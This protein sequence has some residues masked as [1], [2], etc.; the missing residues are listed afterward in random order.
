VKYMRWE[1]R[2]EPGRSR[3]EE[4][5]TCLSEGVSLLTSAPASEQGFMV[6]TRAREQKGP[7]DEPGGGRARHSARRARA[8][9]RQV[10]AV[11]YSQRSG[12]QSRRPRS[13]A[14]YSRLG[15]LL[16]GF[17]CLICGLS[18]TRALADTNFDQTSVLIVVGA[19]GEP[20]YETNFVRQA[21]LWEKACDLAGCRQTTL[22]LEP[23]RGT[24]DLD[25]LKEALAAEPRNGNGQFWLVLIGH[26]TFDGEEA[27]F[28]LRGP[29]V[30]DATLAEWL[31]PFRRP[32][33]VIDTTSSSAPFLVKLSATNRVVV[34]ATRSGYEQNF[35]R[36]GLCFAEALSDPE[37]DLDQDGVVS[38]LEAFLSASRKADEFY[39]VQGRIVT[40]HALLDDNGDHLG[41][42][43]D[44]FQGLQPKHKPEGTAKVDGSLAGQFHLIP[45]EIERMLT[46]AQRAQRDA[47]ERAVL[48][49]REKKDQM[50]EDEYYRG[51]DQ[52]LLEL[53]RFYATNSLLGPVS[54]SK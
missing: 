18:G 25:R 7:S 27:R 14:P 29:D 17:L 13:D 44:W 12:W 36:F 49:Y 6:P 40:E 4:A 45:S 10:R 9:S 23:E 15:P 28:N 16:I 32:L 42:P 8:L 26:G 51:L 3:R 21:T 20:E 31:A 52:R 35:T 34:T 53:A 30:S 46:P 19:P 48:L 33:V 54:T 1:A 37:A 38:V 5:L 11:E 24:N 2:R 47:L 43:A 50:D 22:G 39:K 41:T